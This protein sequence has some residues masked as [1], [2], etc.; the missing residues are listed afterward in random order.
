MLGYGA[1]TIS[2]AWLLRDV[3]VNNWIQWGYGSFM[4]VGGVVDLRSTLGK[5]RARMCDEGQAKE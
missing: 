3:Q 1:V 2:D 4:V 5:R